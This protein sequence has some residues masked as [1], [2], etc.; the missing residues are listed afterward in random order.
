MFQAGD[1]LLNHG[2]LYKVEKIQ[3]KK[4]D[5]E[6]KELVVYAPLFPQKR[7]KTLKCKIPVD[8]VKAAGLRK[9]IDKTKLKKEIKQLTKIDM[10]KGLPSN[11]SS[12]AKDLNNFPKMF[13]LLARLWYMKKTGEKSLSYSK[14]QLYSYLTTN[15]S[16][17]LAVIWDVK[18]EEAKKKLLKQ[19]KQELLE[20]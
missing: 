3:E 6:T 19:F 4:V 2:Q 20:A 9:P 16:Q 1:V 11:R 12:I 10:E 7:N 8:R 17:E 13:R 15:L 14:K 5:D 18:P